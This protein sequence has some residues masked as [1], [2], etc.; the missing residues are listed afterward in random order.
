[1]YIYYCI[2]VKITYAF[3]GLTKLFVASVDTFSKRQ[4]RHSIRTPSQKADGKPISK[5][6]V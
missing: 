5:L 6:A 1:M 2:H 4:D 3:I